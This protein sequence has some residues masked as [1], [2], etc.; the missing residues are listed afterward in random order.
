MQVEMSP[1]I[2]I[3]AQCRFFMTHSIVGSV[4]CDMRGGGFGCMCLDVVGGPATCL[5]GSIPGMPSRI[6]KRAS[7]DIK[8]T[9]NVSKSMQSPFNSS[10][11]HVRKLRLLGARDEQSMHV[12]VVYTGLLHDE[13]VAQ[14][15]LAGEHYSSEDVRVEPFVVTVNHQD[16]TVIELG[17]CVLR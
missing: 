14:W 7:L 16:I 2:S 3:N 4:I 8:W 11:H 12:K 10:L 1:V 17:H 13:C 6:V 5:A 15:H 9:P